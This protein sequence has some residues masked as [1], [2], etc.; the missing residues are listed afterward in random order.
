MII[1]GLE[2]VIHLFIYLLSFPSYHDL[3][4]WQWAIYMVSNYFDKFIETDR[5]QWEHLFFK[6]DTQT[7]VSILGEG[8]EFKDIP[9][10]NQPSFAPELSI[11]ISVITC[12]PT[13]ARN[14][15][16]VLIPSFPLAHVPGCWPCSAD[17][18]CSLLGRCPDFHLSTT[19]LVQLL[20]CSPQAGVTSS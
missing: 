9:E 6:F 3:D 18:P 16:T 12:T 13:C 2:F 11:W 10:L 4:I 1:L 14:P 17:F 19:M 8:R 20:L 7:L 15:G 5:G